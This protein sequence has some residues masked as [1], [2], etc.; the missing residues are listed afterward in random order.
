[1]NY[2]TIFCLVIWNELLLLISNLPSTVWLLVI[3]IHKYA[4]AAHAQ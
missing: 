1:M 4:A 3:D 2:V